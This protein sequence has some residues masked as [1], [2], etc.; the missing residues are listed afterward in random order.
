MKT[1]NNVSNELWENIN[2]EPAN[3]EKAFEL[4]PSEFYLSAV[5]L[6]SINAQKWE[7]AIIYYQKLVI[8]HPEK[9][10]FQ[11]NLATAYQETGKYKEAIAILS[12][13]VA[14]NPKSI[15]MGQRLAECYEKT[16]DIKK[17][18]EYYKMK[19][20][21][22]CFYYARSFTSCYSCFCYGKTFF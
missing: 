3:F 7:K 4:E 20:I 21:G 11:Y 1:E 2:G 6:A 10:N 14:T 12:Q 16:N 9:Q 13:L 19:C 8:L 18:Y 17:A 5:A 22:R 15:S